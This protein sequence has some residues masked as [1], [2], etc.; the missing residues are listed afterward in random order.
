MAEFLAPRLG[1]ISPWSSKATEIARQ[2][3][4]AAG[5]AHRARHGL[6]PRRRKVGDL[7]PRCHCCTTA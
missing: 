2:C 4:F 1:T 6:P 7:A 5:H 3:G